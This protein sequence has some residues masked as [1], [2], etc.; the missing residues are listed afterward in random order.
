MMKKAALAQLLRLTIQKVLGFL[1]F[2]L[3]SKW[4]LNLEAIIFFSFYIVGNLILGIILLIIKPDTLASRNNIKT[5]SPWWDKVLLL[6]FFLLNYFVIFYLAG[7]TYQDNWLL[8]FIGL[9]IYVFAGYIAFYA[10]ISNTYLEPTARIQNDR[11]Q[12]VCQSGP[13]KIIRHPTYLSIILGSISMSLIFMSI[14]VGLC[15]LIIIIIIIIR[16]YLEDKMLINGLKGYKEYSQKTKYRL[17][18]FIW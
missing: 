11:S 5:D 8:L 13:Y 2:L 14:W 4:V 7:K 10:I 17:I 6:V 18:P 1:L 16:T 3:G 9:A 15:A 12:S